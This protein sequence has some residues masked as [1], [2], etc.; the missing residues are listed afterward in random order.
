MRRIQAV[1]AKGRFMTHENLQENSAGLIAAS[2]ERSKLAAARIAD[3]IYKTPLLPSQRN[4]PSGR[5]GLFFKA[6]NFQITGSFKIRGA[7]AKMTALGAD[8]PVITASSG[9]HGIACAR[10]A[11]AIGVDLT[12]VLPETVARKKLEAIKAMGT[13]V[14]LHGGE[15]G[16]SELYARKLAE[17]KGHIYVSPYNDAEIIAGQGTIGLELLSQADRIDNI[18]ISL[19]GG[20]LVSGI[21]AVLKAASPHTRVIGVA[22]DH[23]CALAASIAAGQVVETE[24]KPTLADGVAGGVDEG[25][26]TL[27]IAMSVI[28]DVVHCSEQQIAQAVRTM[29]FSE[30]QL[31][32]G[33][34]ALALAG[35]EMI[36]DECKDQVNIVLLCGANYDQNVILPLLK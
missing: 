19:G 16:Q 28:D 25:S 7:A 26:L 29:A 27:P 2:A 9:N 15:S 20:G 35:Y 34:A 6:E 13:D 11:A 1:L 12:I 5:G 30:N 22:A 36:A 18:F 21:G 8:Q 17:D 3:Y 4:D 32:E 10:A 31:V 23:S 14:I 24:H 33:A